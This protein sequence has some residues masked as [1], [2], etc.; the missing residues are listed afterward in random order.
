MAKKVAFLSDY[1]FTGSWAQLHT[2]VHDRILAENP[3]YIIGAGDV[4]DS[5]TTAQYGYYNSNISSYAGFHAK[6]LPTAGNHDDASGNLNNWWSTFGSGSGAYA[7]GT[8]ASAP[9]YSTDIGGWHC[10]SLFIYPGSPSYATGSAQYNWLVADLAAVPSGTPILGFWHMPRFSIDKTHGDNKPDGTSGNPATERA[11]AASVAPIWDLFQDAGADLILNGHCHINQAFPRMNSNATLNSASGIQELAT[12]GM[13]NRSLDLTYS[14]ATPTYYSGSVA[15]ERAI[16][17]LTLRATSQG[18][19]DTGYDWKYVNVASGATMASGSEVSHKSAGSG[20]SLRHYRIGTLPDNPATGGQEIT[21]NSGTVDSR[22][23]DGVFWIINDNGGSPLWAVDYGSPANYTE[24][25]WPDVTTDAPQLGFRKQFTVTGTGGVTPTGTGQWEDLAYD[26]RPGKNHI[27]VANCGNNGY[28]STDKTFWLWQIPEPTSLTSPNT[29]GSV[30]ATKGWAVKWPASM[31]TGSTGVDCEAFVVV[32]VDIPAYGVQAGTV[33]FFPKQGESDKAMFC[34]PGR[35]EDLTGGQGIVYTL[36]KK[37]PSLNWYGKATRADWVPDGS[38]LIVANDPGFGA[39]ATEKHQFYGGPA[40]SNSAYVYD[41]QTL[42]VKRK[43][44]IV[45]AWGQGRYNA[46]NYDG[47]YGNESLH[48]SK[49]S[50]VDNQT[51]YVGVDSGASAEN[52]DVAKTEYS[53]GSSPPPPPPDPDPLNVM[54]IKSGG[55]WISATVWAD[56]ANKVVVPPTTNLLANPSFEIGGA[57]NWDAALTHTIT[58]ATNT[59]HEGSTTGV[60]TAVSP[61]GNATLYSDPEVLPTLEGTYSANVW[62]KWKT[63]GPR[64]IRLDIQW[65]DSLG[66]TAPFNSAQ[67]SSTPTNTSTWT[68]LTV[69]GAVAP[70]GAVYAKLRV[71]AI[72]PLNNEQYYI[73]D[74]ELTDDS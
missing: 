57:A 36:V 74:C 71:V 41:G 47:S 51:I 32:P 69:T 54:K 56:P 15:G 70:A 63:G 6:T 68:N 25:P 35:P 19:A 38:E 59:F 4:A 9:W 12:S 20:P 66:S 24:T 13:Q 17:V 72:S 52:N 73:D 23:H 18:D 29:V 50:T 3:N 67:G 22:L 16:I 28:V 58:T 39:S 31:H 5:G 34:M 53:T 33:C 30:A 55:V 46:G 26:D 42:A 14:I 43:Q 60:F 11:N 37:G 44:E 2:D 48:F 62:V 49:E 7:Y 40:E 21:E 27:Y 64:N 10:I 45:L 61:T 65:E 1:H 8:S